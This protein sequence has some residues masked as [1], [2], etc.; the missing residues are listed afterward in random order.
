MRNGGTF[1]C[2][3][4]W[5]HFPGIVFFEEHNLEREWRES[6]VSRSSK[7]ANAPS[8]PRPLLLMLSRNVNA[9]AH[10]GRKGFLSYK[11]GC[12]GEGLRRPR[13]IHVSCMIRRVDDD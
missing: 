6:V 1:E 8:L 3:M 5:P 11:R 7:I 4:G 2:A 9:G 13:P 10:C 12:C